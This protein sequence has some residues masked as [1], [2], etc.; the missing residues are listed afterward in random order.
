[1]LAMLAT[2]GASLAADKSV[3]PALKLRGGLAGVDP[4]MAATVGSTLFGINGVVCGLAEGVAT[5]GYGVKDASYNIQQMVKSLGFTFISFAVLAISLLKGVPFSAAFG[6]GCLPWLLLTISNILNGVP[7]KMG[8]P[9]A[10]QYLLLAINAASMYCGLTDTAMP[11]AAKLNAGWTLLNGVAF[12]L[13]PKM[14]AKGWGL[15]E[16]DKFAAI[17][18]NF[19]YSLVAMG[20]LIMSTATGVAVEQA[21]GYAMIPMLVSLLDGLYINKGFDTLNADKVPAYVWGAIMTTVI[22]LTLS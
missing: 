8:M 20:T 4:K 19:G 13:V 12:A 14:G 16:D 21:V 11:L 1:M 6:W 22:A 9:I 18:K 2:A 10:G 7:A 17:F 5:E 3:R 15:V